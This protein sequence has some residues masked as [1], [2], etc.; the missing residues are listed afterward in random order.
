V[1]LFDRVLSY[2]SI[3]VLGFVVYLLSKRSHFR[4]PV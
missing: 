3:A 4:Q 1:V 2:L